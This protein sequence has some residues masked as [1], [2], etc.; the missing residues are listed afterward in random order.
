MFNMNIGKGKYLLSG[1]HGTI[2]ITNCSFLQSH[3][4]YF[5][6]LTL[7]IDSCNYNSNYRE[8]YNTVC[9]NT[10]G[11]ITNT[12]FE[13]SLDYDYTG[14]IL[15]LRNS[16]LDLLENIFKNN[17]R[18]CITFSGGIYKVENNS[19]LYNSN[20]ILFTDTSYVALV[21]NEI[22]NNSG[23]GLLFRFHDSPG[24]FTGN[25]VVNNSASNQL[26]Y[27]E[28]GNKN[29]DSLYITNNTICNN[30]LTNT[31]L[32]Y[33]IDARE[34][35]IFQ[36]NIIRNNISRGICRYGDPQKLFFRN[37]NIEGL[38]SKIVHETSLQPGPGVFFENNFDVDPFFVNPTSNA[39]AEY[40][41]EITEW[42]LEPYS[43]CINNG[44]QDT[45]GLKLPDKDIAGNDRIN[46]SIDIG[47]LEFMG[48]IVTVPK[49][50]VACD[51]IHFGRVKTG[52]Q[53]EEFNIDIK[54]FGQGVLSIDSITCSVD[55]GFRVDDS[56]GYIN[57]LTDIEVEGSDIL[58]C[59][60]VCI[61]CTKHHLEGE[62]NIYSNDGHYTVY[63]EGEAME[64]FYLGGTINI[65]QTLSG[66]VNIFSNVTISENAEIFIAPGTV[67]NFEDNYMI[68]VNGTLIAEGTEEDSIYFTGQV[69]YSDSENCWGGIL[70]QGTWDQTP[71]PDS[72]FLDYCVFTKSIS[73]IKAENYSNLKISNC[74]FKDNFKVLNLYTSAA[75]VTNNSFVDN[76][77]RYGV[78]TIV[79]QPQD[80][81]FTKIYNNI[82]S[83]N[84]VSSAN[85]IHF[86][87][88]FRANIINNLFIN[89]TCARGVISYLFG[90][91]SYFI[92]NTVCNNSG[93]VFYLDASINQS[94]KLNLTI[95][96]SIFYKNGDS[97]YN[98][99]N[100]RTSNTNIVIQSNCFEENSF[101][102]KEKNMTK[103]L[104]D[105]SNNIISNP[106]FV[107]PVAE[108]NIENNNDLGNWKLC[109]DSP[110]IDRGDTSIT[111]ILPEYDL[112]GNPRINNRIDIGAFEYLLPVNINPENEILPDNYNLLQNFPNPFNPVTTIK[113]SIPVKAGNAALASPTKVELVIYDI[114]GCKVKT[115]V[116]EIQMP[117]IYSVKFDASKLSSGIYIYRLITDSFTESRKLV[118]MK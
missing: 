10:V 109:E 90:G 28:G 81:M 45:T 37:N 92:N 56:T 116:N 73:G 62:L 42:S 32:T 74:L 26:L 47:A 64:D 83:N 31:Y 39:G 38:I 80:S 95:K 36:N 88:L 114:L 101:G 65:S 22:R 6:N 50:Y 111:V 55:F 77:I 9:Q 85:I 40:E 33:L 13:S 44:L 97:E 15:D 82:F 25:L 16:E 51:S 79:F 104:E 69:Y 96:N 58:K 93:G 89:N 17:V 48:E 21:N 57:K 110:C 46:E 118:L 11:T 98:F 7:T 106:L 67:I 18:N 84:K 75:L 1:D 68:T 72:S 70:F 59:F 99:M 43:F 30:I 12:L 53:S 23:S 100:D 3:G 66:K 103:V 78:I 71:F 29:L 86:G 14:S 108:F 63:L 112:S 4:Q 117:G 107:N 49:I 105:G 34:P 41:S 35:T 54:N 19:F 94:K 5:A 24:H 113:Y 102:C 61:P 2:D 87:S 52:A 20:S 27:I 76:D 8:E 60:T 91:D 115:L